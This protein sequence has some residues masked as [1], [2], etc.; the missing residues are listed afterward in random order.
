MVS[1]TLVNDTDIVAVD[2]SGSDTNWCEKLVI[3]NPYGRKSIDEN[4]AY[5]WAV[6]D[7]GRERLYIAYEKW[8]GDSCSAVTVAINRGMI[9][10]IT[11]IDNVSEA[12]GDSYRYPKLVISTY[13]NNYL[14]LVFTDY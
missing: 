10:S 9:E 3:I 12:V 5:P 4:A 13:G 6:E 8:L 11:T 1:P 14:I 2:V 7:E